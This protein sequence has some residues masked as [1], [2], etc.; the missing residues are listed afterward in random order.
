MKE[1][2]TQIEPATLSDRI[3]RLIED[4]IVDGTLGPGGILNSDALARQFN[5]SHIPV[6]EALQKLTAIGLVVQEANKSA[7]IAQLS[8][9]DITHIFQVRQALEGLAASLAATQMD[10]RS[11]KRL[12]LLVRRMRACAKSRD[13]AK[14][15]AADKEFHH[16]I[17]RLSGNN[18]LV[19]ILSTLLLPYFGYLATRGYHVHQSDPNYVPRVH[20]EILDAL[21]TRDSGHA[22]R[23]LISVLERSRKLMPAP[24]SSS[25]IEE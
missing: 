14:L 24:G 2:F 13:F 15:F 7:R 12:Q 8:N 23:V 16:T 18:L 1:L 6:R 3:A 5:V 21:A 19:K 4:A 10:S 22:Q 17:W 11:Q 20:Q 25:S 9:G